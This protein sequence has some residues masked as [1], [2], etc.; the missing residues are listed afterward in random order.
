MPE[1][2]VL[3]QA[4]KIGPPDILLLPPQVVCEERLSTRPGRR[5]AVVNL[6]PMNFAA[7]EPA[8]LSKCD[9]LLS[10]Q[11]GSNV[12]QPEA[13]EVAA[14]KGQRVMNCV[15]EHLHSTADPD[16]RNAK[17]CDSCHLGG[18]SGGAQVA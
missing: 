2:R 18:K 3:E 16:D 4:V 12:E 7:V 13:I 1:R 17:H 8:R 5:A 6:V 15:P 14:F 11:N 10:R 9:C